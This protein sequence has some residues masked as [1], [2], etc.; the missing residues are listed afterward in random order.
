MTV[1]EK[2]LQAGFLLSLFSRP[3]RWRRY[4]PPKRLL[5]FNGLH[6]VI[7][8]KMVHF[9]TTG[10]RTSD[11]TNRLKFPLRYVAHWLLL[12]LYRRVHFQPTI[13]VR[14]PFLQNICRNQWTVRIFQLR[15]APFHHV[16]QLTQLLVRNPV[17]KDRS[18]PSGEVGSV[19][20]FTS[21]S[22]DKQFSQY[23]ETSSTSINTE[24]LCDFKSSRWWVLRL[25]SS[26]M[27]RRVVW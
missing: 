18:R 13:T 27:W 10:V 7:S 21:V 11:P 2:G 23:K 12:L 20:C 15:G 22:N 1:S 25:W 24:F 6:G 3:W 16:L 9:I 19:Q 4:V 17:L 8:Q 5:T 26:G 14:W